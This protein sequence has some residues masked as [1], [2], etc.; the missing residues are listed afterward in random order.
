MT[1]IGEMTGLSKLKYP[2]TIALHVHCIVLNTVSYT[3]LWLHTA[4]STFGFFFIQNTH[5][6]LGFTLHTIQ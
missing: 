2:H 1:G 3:L 6:K 4:Y 5:F